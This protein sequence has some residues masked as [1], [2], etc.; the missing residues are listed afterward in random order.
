MHDEIPKLNIIMDR[1]HLTFLERNIWNEEP[2]SCQLV[3]NNLSHDAGI[4]YRGNHTRKFQKKS[5]KIDFGIYNEEF[6]AREMHLNAEFC[7]PSF[8]R[9]KLSF[10]FF[11]M[12]GSIS[13][14]CNHVLIEM[15]GE[16]AGIYL[17][18]ES[19]DDVFLQKRHLPYGPI[20]YASNRQ[21]NFSLLTTKGEPKESLTSGYVRK[22]G[23]EEDDLDLER[24]IIKINSIPRND[25]G[26]EIGEYLDVKKYLTWLSGA[27]CTQNYDGFIQNYALYRHGQ[28]GLYEN[29]PWDYDATFGRNWN[30]KAMKYNQV[31]IEGFNTLTA[32][33]LDVKEFRI[34]Y[35]LLLE[36][37]VEEYFTVKKIEP[38][39][40]NLYNKL[41][42]HI[43]FDPYK[44]TDI[45]LFEREPEFILQFIL[46]R[47]HYL[48]DH[49]DEL[50]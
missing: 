14:D 26:E 45:E 11:K 19:V 21:S 6:E 38:M 34:Q 20:Y 22:L 17:Q 42:P 41:R 35:R 16:P 33:I 48:R 27:V 23:K 30:G 44:M 10:D 43:A 18:L 3:D 49:L 5:Y 29:I 36:E 15:N 31:P 28:T 2:I 37:I 46:N 50:I 4:T 24:L 32:R 13:P 7:D 39:I 9:N 12:I 1:E 8:I 47:N 40:T 25:F